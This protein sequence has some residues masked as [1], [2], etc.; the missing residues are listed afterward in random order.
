MAENERFFP[1]ESVDEQIER[2]LMQQGNSSQEEASK[3]LIQDLHHAYQHQAEQRQQTLDHAWQRI[4]QRNRLIESPTSPLPPVT[5]MRPRRNWSR[6][7]QFSM[8]AAVLVTCLLVGSLLVVLNIAR[9]SQSPAS[10]NV[11][12]AT[13]TAPATAVVPTKLGET[14]FTAQDSSAIYSV[15]WSPD[16]T[17][18]A[19]ASKTVQIWDAKNGAHKLTITPDQVSGPFAARWSPDGKYIATATSGLQ[20]WDATGKNVASCSDPLQQ[21]TLFTTSGGSPGSST[22]ET[23]RIALKRLSTSAVALSNKDQEPVNLSWSPD[24]KQVAFTY[25]KQ[26]HPMVV[27][28]NVASCK[29]THSYSYKNDV[30]YDVKWS[31]D[32]KY[33]AVSTNDRIVQIHEI[34]K[35]KPVYTY[36]DPYDTDIFSFD[37][38]PDSK[39]IASASYGSGKIEVWNALNGD[40]QHELAANARPATRLAWSHDGG[41]IVSVSEPAEGDAAGVVRIWNEQTARVLYTY[42][43]HKHL[44]LAVAWSPDGKWIASAEGMPDAGTNMSGNGAVKV[45]LAQ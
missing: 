9:S 10:Q 22:N 34:G 37:W 18:L 4:Q 20:V 45:W 31:P 26:G 13:S 32:G 1:P 42:S 23:S 40:V 21:V 41:K 33:I 29:V 11:P 38:S 3:R 7:Q 8:I 15:D 6:S 28:E 16:G 14:L 25:R 2:L 35:D 24:S 36:E 12:T 43:G 30:P 39:Y 19:S 27:V 5:Q 44:V 17:L